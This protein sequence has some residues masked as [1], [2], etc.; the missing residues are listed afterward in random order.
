[1]SDE[2]QGGE[3]GGQESATETWLE[4]AA[5]GSSWLGRGA[6]LVEGAEHLGMIGEL[7]ETAGKALPGVG[8]VMGGI[9]GGINLGMAVNDFSK[10]GAHSD[11]GYEHLGGAALGGAGAALSC[12]PYGAALAAGE[13]VTDL[14]GAGMGKLFGEKAGFSA[15]SVAGGLIRGT[16]GDKSLGWGAGSWVSDHLGG[17]T[18]GK[19]AGVGTGALVNAATLPINLA[20]TVGTGLWDEGKAIWGGLNDPNTLAGKGVKA[21]GS[22]LSSAWGGIKSAGSAIGSGLSSAGSAIG[23]AASSAWGGMKSVGSGI[24]HAIS[25]FLSDEQLK[26]DVTPIHG[27]LAR[28]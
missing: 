26:T 2:G 8:A 9:S 11:K 5:K 1:M 7:G 17:G 22:G 10:E 28:L 14:A 15:D 19:V 4:R 3:G 21:V 27:A 24:G 6:H 18:L 25:S 23:G 12:T 20:K 13:V 16:M